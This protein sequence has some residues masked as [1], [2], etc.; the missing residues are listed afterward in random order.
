MSVKTSCSRTLIS[1]AWL[2][3]YP[4]WGISLFQITAPKGEIW[5]LNAGLCPC[6]RRRFPWVL[7]ALPKFTF[8]TTSDPPTVNRPAPRFPANKQVILGALTRG[9][10]VLLNT[11]SV[12]PRGRM[13]PSKRSVPSGLETTMP[14]MQGAGGACSVLWPLQQQ[15]ISHLVPKA[16]TQ[17]CQRAQRSPQNPVNCR[18]HWWEYNLELNIHFLQYF[19]TNPIEK[20]PALPWKKRTQDT[21]CGILPASSPSPLYLGGLSREASTHQHAL[22]F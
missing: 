5:D 1:A 12:A 15:P 16:F 14:S 2:T 21:N 8:L 22:P 11:R 20:F 4:R 13:D 6:L 9:A 18:R 7:N 10:G 19:Q 3:L 17:P